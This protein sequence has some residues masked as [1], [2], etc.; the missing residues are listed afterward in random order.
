MITFLG[1]L[2]A[3]PTRQVQ[4]SIKRFAKLSICFIIS[5]TRIARNTITSQAKFHCNVL[6]NYTAIKKKTVRVQTYLSQ[7]SKK[8]A[9]RNS[10]SIMS[11]KSNPSCCSRETIIPISPM[12]LKERLR[13]PA[14]VI[15]YCL[16]KP[17]SH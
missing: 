7:C 5:S 17:S 6:N 8:P 4:A 10:S 16:E 13:L 11:S 15:S 2:K 12:N 9:A 14:T 1:I 3:I